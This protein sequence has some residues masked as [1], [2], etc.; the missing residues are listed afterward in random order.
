VLRV[1]YDKSGLRSLVVSAPDFAYIQ[2]RKDLFSSAAIEDPWA[3]DF[4]YSSGEWPQNLV[5]AMVTWQWFRVFLATPLLGRTFTK[6]EERNSSGG[7]GRYGSREG[8]AA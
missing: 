2:E 5:G 4:N 3:S 1:K 8:A 6:Q 7:Q